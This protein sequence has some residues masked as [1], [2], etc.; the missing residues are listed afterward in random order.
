MDDIVEKWQS[1]IRNLKSKSY[2]ISS[3]KKYIVRANIANVVLKENKC[4][5][6]VSL[7]KNNILNFVENLVLKQG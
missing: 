1:D 6:H 3:H 7:F 4:K 2:L 5:S